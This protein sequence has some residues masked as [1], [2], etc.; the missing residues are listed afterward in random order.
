MV[1]S[2]SSIATATSSSLKV[3]SERIRAAMA[4]RSGGASL[5][6]RILRPLPRDLADLPDEL[7]K[8]H[9]RCA[10]RASH[11]GI[12]ADV[13]VGVHVDHV[14]CA[15]L[16]HAEVHPRIIAELEGPERP[17]RGPLDGGL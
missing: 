11:S 4:P 3:S 15:V 17:D 6:M 8:I 10:R 2:T 14:R 12:R 7:R 16:R 1:S 13:A 9:P 5:R